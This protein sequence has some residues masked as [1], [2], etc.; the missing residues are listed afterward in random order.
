MVFI[1]R[2]NLEYNWILTTEQW[3]SLS[4]RKY[5]NHIIMSMVEAGIRVGIEDQSGIT[6]AYL[7]IDELGMLKY[8]YV[9]LRS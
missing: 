2:K 4:E 6:Y 3:E 1:E 7:V 5:D 8:D 9:G